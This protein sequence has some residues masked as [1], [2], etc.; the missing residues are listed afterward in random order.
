MGI[1]DND[2]PQQLLADD[3]G[4]IKVVL[5]AYEH[6]KSRI[7]N[8]TEQFL[9]HIHLEGHQ[10]FIVTFASATEVAAFL[11]TQNAT[12]NEVLFSSGEFVEFDREAGDIVI[13]NTSQDAID[14]LLFG[15]EH[16][17]EP[18]VAQGPF[19]MNTNQEIAQ[20]Y[21]DFYEG[22]YGQITYEKQ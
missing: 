13:S 21:N 4:W 10:Q 19:V 9:Y 18:I 20:A 22:K 7:P 12:L 16:Y 3:K 2:V 11:P 1:Q 6:L 17:S 14:I 15:G 5:G 8:Y